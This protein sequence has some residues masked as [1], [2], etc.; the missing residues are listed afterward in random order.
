MKETLKF[1]NDMAVVRISAF[2]GF[3][4]W[5]HGQTVPFIADDPDPL[6]WAYLAD[7]IRFMKGKRVID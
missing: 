3:G 7:W 4:E 1:W 2:K 5:L 6:D